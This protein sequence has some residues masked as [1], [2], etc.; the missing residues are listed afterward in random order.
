MARLLGFSLS[1]LVIK[2][3]VHFSEIQSQDHDEDDD[4]APGFTDSALLVKVE[5]DV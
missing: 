3:W 2:V 1:T 4:D 5:G